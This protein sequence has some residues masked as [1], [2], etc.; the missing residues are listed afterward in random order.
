MA[1]SVDPDEMP[2]S[3]VS[4]LGLN[5]LLRPVC[6]N[7]CGKYGNEAML[8]QLY[9]INHFHLLINFLPINSLSSQNEGN[10]SAQNERN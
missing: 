10:Q 3:V 1:N 7:T 2:Y 5:Y 6:P 4:H 8:L 9:P